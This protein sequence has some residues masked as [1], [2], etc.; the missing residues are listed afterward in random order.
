M[1][2]ERRDSRINLR[3]DGGLRA[4]IEGTARDLDCSLSM[5]TRYLVGLGVAFEQIKGQADPFASADELLRQIA[6]IEVSAFRQGGRERFIREVKDLLRQ[7]GINPP[8][9]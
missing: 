6:A 4:A 8:R 5:A 7:R 9:I 1:N 3:L 2:R